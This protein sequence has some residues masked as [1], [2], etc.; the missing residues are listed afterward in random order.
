VIEKR[1]EVIQATNRESAT[2][3]TGRAT[4]SLIPPLLCAIAYAFCVLLMAAPLS[5]AYDPVLRLQVPFGDWLTQVGAWLPA[6]W[7]L[8]PIPRHAQTNTSMLQ[9]LGLTALAFVIYGLCA[10]YISRLPAESKRYRHTRLILW[11]GATLAGLFFVFTP[12]MLSHDILVYA[13]YSRLLA[14]YHANPYFVPLAAFPH[15][16]YVLLN[17]WSG[18]VSAYGPL[19]LGVCWLVGLVVGPQVAAYVLAFRLFALAVHLLNIWLV[20]RTLRAMGA[21]P[22]AITLGTL[23]YAWNPLVLLESGLGGH[24]DVFMLTF[25]L[26]GIYH[27]ARAQQRN[28]LTSPRGYLV[29][30]VAFTLAVLV[31]FTALPLIALFLVFLAWNTLRGSA[32]TNAEARAQGALQWKKTIIAVFIAGATAGALALAF[33]GPF[34]IGHSVSAIR[35]SFTSPPS[36]V[37]SENSIL[38]SILTWNRD[39]SIPAQTLQSKLIYIFSNRKVWDALNFVLL[40][41]VGLR[42]ALWMWRSPTTRTFTLSALAALGVLLIVTPWFF[43]WYITWLVGLAAVALPVRQ[44]R[45]GCALLVSTLAFSASAFLTYLFLSGYPPFGIWTGLVCLTTITPP[46][47]AFLITYLFW[48]PAKDMHLSGSQ[49]VH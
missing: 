36:A 5:R 34:W 45:I 12:T 43:S 47:L 4:L 25:I 15:D 23:L 8:G 44:S 16:P 49:I 39:H 32:A 11:A 26:L 10:L 42:S 14:I 2:P 48:Q 24:N 29:P 6:N 41:I 7:G 17:Y 20:T 9:F 37:G 13:S 38:R 40:A 33:Y 28:T 30:V 21:S 1:D 46:L 31:K 3:D 27:M 22:R 35:N 19:W 18:S